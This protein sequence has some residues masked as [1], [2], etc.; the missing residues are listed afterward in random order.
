MWTGYA[1][2]HYARWEFASGPEHSNRTQEAASVG[3]L[4]KLQN[5]SVLVEFICFRRSWTVPADGYCPN[6]EALGLN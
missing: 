6:S 5:L 4:F 3:G 1:S 2:W